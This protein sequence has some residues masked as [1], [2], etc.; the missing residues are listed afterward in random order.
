MFTEFEKM[1][2]HSRIWIYQ[3]DRELSEKESNVVA[4]TLKNALQDW[5][6]HGAPLVGSFT[7]EF[8]RFIIIALDP[9]HNEAS[10]CSIDSSTKWLKEL[11]QQLNIDFFDRS[12]AY[13]EGK[14][15][16][17]FNIFQAK[18]SVESGLI[19][20]NTL[21]FNNNLPE[22]ASLLSQWKIPAS[23]TYLAKYFISEA[24]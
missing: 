13:L 9:S 20:E 6:A 18:K 4:Y 2:S 22:L 17:T 14:E 8:K 3:T 15:I 10:G 23:K 19:T 16:K 5:A 11:G 7:I 12:Q 24:V 21:V 1:S